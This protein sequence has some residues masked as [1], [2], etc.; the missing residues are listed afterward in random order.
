MYGSRSQLRKQELPKQ[1]WTSQW[2]NNFYDRKQSIMTE[3]I[4]IDR[5]TSQYYL[6][7]YKYK[8]L[9][10]NANL[11]SLCS[12]TYHAAAPVTTIP[13]S[14]SCETPSSSSNIIASLHLLLMWYLPPST[15]TPTG[16][17]LWH[18]TLTE[19]TGSKSQLWQSRWK[20]FLIDFLAKFGFCPPKLG[21]FGGVGGPGGSANGL[22]G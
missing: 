2:F 19:K 6:N 16:P 20:L 9:I 18:W 11:S 21:F 4:F 15:P 3:K 1:T 10:F 22:V 13:I 5:L 17:C 14:S 8:N 7:H 12:V